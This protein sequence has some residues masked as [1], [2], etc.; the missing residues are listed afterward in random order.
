MKKSAIAAGILALSVLACSCDSKKQDGTRTTRETKE[1]KTTTTETT[2][3][4]TSSEETS[5]EETTTE[6]TTT[7]TK[8]ETT[9][10]TTEETT[11]ETTSEETSEDTSATSEETSATAE[12]TAPKAEPT[13]DLEKDL[14]SYYADATYTFPEKIATY[15]SAGTISWNQNVTINTSDWTIIGNYESFMMNLDGDQERY[16]GYLSYF[17]SKVSPLERINDYSF[18]TTVSGLSWSTGADYEGTH[19]NLPCDYHYAPPYKL[20]EGDELILYLPNT[21]ISEF[22]KAASDWVNYALLPPAG[23]YLQAFVMFNATTETAY[24]VYIP[25]LRATEKTSGN[26]MDGWYGTFTSDEGDM[27]IYEDPA[28]GEPRMDLLFRNCKQYKNMSVRKA[29][30]DAASIYAFGEAEDGTLIIIGVDVADGTSV[31]AVYE[32]GDEGLPQGSYVSVYKKS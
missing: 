26:D 15:M 13:Y 7:E 22:P 17:K 25:A 11:E 3:E 31:L 5:T 19:E 12:T 18:K 27:K 23:G 6:E 14:Y 9:V 32:S 16:D 28:T 20:N 4:T 24:I 10:T 2:E 8:E 21:P 29:L 1:P 30:D